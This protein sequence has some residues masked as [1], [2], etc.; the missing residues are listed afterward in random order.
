MQGRMALPQDEM[1]A[2][3][4]QRAPEFDRWWETTGPYDGRERPGWG[5]ELQELQHLVGSLP[6][7]RVL[8]VGCG[9][10]FV[11][12]LLR[13]PLVAGVDPSPAMLARARARLPGVFFARADGLALPFGAG[14]FDRVF[15]SHVYGH[16]LPA[17]REGFREE[18][19]RVGRELVVVD[20]GPR[21]GPPREEWQD[22]TLRDGTRHRVYKRFFDAGALMV[23]LGGAKVLHEGHWFVAVLAVR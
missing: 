1:R 16:L 3:Y 2:Y 13:G 14:A 8:D 15:T 9:T 18:A 23:E 19:F 5:E 10:G 4:E 21:G 20:A 7:V 22:R 6:P 11:T 12:R 17:E